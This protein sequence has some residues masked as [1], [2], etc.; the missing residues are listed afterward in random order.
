L[1]AARSFWDPL[2]SPLIHE[3][4]ARG[5]DHRPWPAPR[6]SWVMAQSWVDLL[7]AH[8]RVPPELLR[9]AVPP[10]LELQ[11]FDGQAWIGVTP[12]EVRNLRLRPTPPLP[13]LSTFAEINVRT[14]VT[15]AGKPGIFFFSL[16]AA[17][18]PAVAAARRF[19][20]LP[21]FEADM[22][23]QR[24]THGLRYHSQRRSGRSAPAAAFQGTYRARGRVNAPAEGTLE[25]WLIERYCL[26]TLDDQQQVLRGDIHH[27]P[28]P[29]QPAEADIAL[30]TMADEVW[31]RAQRRPPTALRG[32]PGR[33]LLDAPASRTPASRPHARARQ[34]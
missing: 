30:N 4:A 10:Q 2:A 34:P 32:A 8:W 14:Y 9:P 12:F 25:H 31:R 6:R 22:S 13:W 16:D 24:D 7:F 33:R 17:S 11:T 18:R 3:R 1:D 20:R 15:F 27:P 23:I 29:L 19:Y 26:Y 28:W 21:Y 5:R